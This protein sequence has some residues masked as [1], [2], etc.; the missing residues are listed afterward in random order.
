M[1][2][3]FTI[4]FISKLV[5]NLCKNFLCIAQH[6]KPTVLRVKELYNYGHTNT[7]YHSLCT[8]DCDF[9]LVIRISSFTMLYQSQIFS[10]YLAHDQR[11]QL[12]ARFFQF[13]VPIPLDNISTSVNFEM[14]FWCL[15]VFQKN[16][17]ENLNFCPSPLGQK[18]FV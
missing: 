11:Y 15:Q 6:Q 8:L 3:I 12:F 17:I 10:H 1:A 16:E 14:S 4:F 7:W 5:S 18:F 13:L 2:Y 9:G